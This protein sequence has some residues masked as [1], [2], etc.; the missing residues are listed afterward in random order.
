LVPALFTSACRT[1]SPVAAPAGD[2]TAAPAATAPAAPAATAPPR[3]SSARIFPSL[4][5]YYLG[6]RQKAGVL[7]ELST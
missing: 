1:G 6:R 7:E 4:L 3:I 2:A 5:I